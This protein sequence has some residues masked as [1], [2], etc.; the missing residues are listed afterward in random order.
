MILKGVRKGVSRGSVGGQLTWGQCFVEAHS[1]DPL[2]SPVSQ[3][4]GLFCLRG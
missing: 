4:G 2:L 3:N 1:H